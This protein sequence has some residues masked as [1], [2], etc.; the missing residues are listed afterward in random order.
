M[1]RLPAN[2]ICRQTTVE[3]QCL[4][5]FQV[6]RAFTL[7]RGKR[8]HVVQNRGSGEKETGPANAP[9][10]SPPDL[11]QRHRC[12]TLASFVS[13]SGPRQCAEG[14]MSPSCP[15]CAIEAWEVPRHHQPKRQ[16]LS[17][18]GSPTQSMLLH[19]SQ[20]GAFPA[21]L[22]GIISKSGSRSKD[23]APKLNHGTV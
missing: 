8:V 13:V 14:S 17:A 5:S 1:N 4:F 10:T 22:F 9:P 2:R 3:Q 20:T 18:S 23:T 21:H 19:Y 16:K 15:P 7:S 12:S 6:S 11:V